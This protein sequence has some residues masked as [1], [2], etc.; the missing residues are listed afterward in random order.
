MAWSLPCRATCPG[1]R[2]V[3]VLPGEH[4]AG[5]CMKV[6]NGPSWAKRAQQRLVR[7]GDKGLDLEGGRST[8]T[9]AIPC[10]IFDYW[11]WLSTRINSPE[12][13]RLV[14]SPK[15]SVLW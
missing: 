6:A 10:L 7:Q 9:R 3:A 13:N 4:P 1:A 12:H 2:G 8:Q 11:W 15:L 5:F 14:T